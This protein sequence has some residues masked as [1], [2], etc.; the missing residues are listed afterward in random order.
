M[1]LNNSSGQTLTSVAL[2]RDVD[3]DASDH[4]VKAG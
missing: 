4:Q 3:I 1:T 2:P